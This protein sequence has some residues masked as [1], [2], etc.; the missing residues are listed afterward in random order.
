MMYAAYL[1]SSSLFAAFITSVLFY[2]VSILGL[3][4]ISCK[5][6]AI[7]SKSNVEQIMKETIRVLSPFLHKQS[8]RGRV[9]RS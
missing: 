2:V 1:W 8:D 3:L 4:S 9:F 7:Q 5:Y 6:L